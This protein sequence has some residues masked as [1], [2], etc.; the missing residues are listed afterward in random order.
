MSNVDPAAIPPAATPDISAQLA[1]LTNLLTEALAKPAASTDDAH[2]A[3]SS[4]AS[5]ASASVSASAPAS[6]V[7]PPAVG[8]FV[9]NVH[10]P[11]G[12]D[13][14]IVRYGI[15]ATVDVD[16]NVAGVVWFLAEPT[17]VPGDA[18]TKVD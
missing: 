13:N 10:T 7:P 8:S 9:S 6:S 14:E 11:P 3:V 2:A 12:T 16:Q 4:S 1:Q 15:V 5:D 18:L 17:T